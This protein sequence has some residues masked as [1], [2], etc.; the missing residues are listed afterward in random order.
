MEADR[1]I[2]MR[3]YLALTNKLNLSNR[4]ADEST[5]LVF[6][7]KVDSTGIPMLLAST[8]NE[9]YLVLA[10]Y[11][12]GFWTEEKDSEYPILCGFIATTLKYKM[13]SAENCHSTIRRA[14]DSIFSI[15][16]I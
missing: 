15:Q 1:K 14:L 9:K 13:L 2:I 3:E 5:K 8:N 11:K 10:H 6:S 7:L 4:K 12:S 16:E